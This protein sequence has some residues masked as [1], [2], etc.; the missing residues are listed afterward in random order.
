M[1]KPRRGGL[2]GD[3]RLLCFP[4]RRRRD[5]IGERMQS[6][7]NAYSLVNRTFEGELE[8]CCV[9]EKV[10]LLAYSP[11][12][13]GY[14]TGKY[15]GGALPEGSRKKLFNRLQRYETPKAEAAINSYLDLADEI[16]ADPAQ[17]A[18]RFCDTR[19]FMGS[20]II[21]AT[22]MDQL[23]TCIDAFAMAW[24]EEIEDRVNALHLAQP[25]PCP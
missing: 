16:G 11:L 3:L 19:P 8:E 25:S 23:K 5:R 14:L 13:Q 17:L 4:G 9:R 10:S 7:Q 12:A 6:I 21:G 24:S 2:G 22:S 15:R 18:I 20:T 1:V